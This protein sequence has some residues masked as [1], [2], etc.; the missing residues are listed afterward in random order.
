MKA[1]PL[2]RDA[3][4]G[5]GFLYFIAVSVFNR[6]TSVSLFR[7]ALEYRD[8]DYHDPQYEAQRE[9]LHEQCSECMYNDLVFKKYNARGPIAGNQI[10]NK[11][12]HIVYPR[13][14]S[15]SMIC[16]TRL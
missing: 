2:P 4:Q 5:E 7:Q 16:I 1:L 11:Q 3:R 6:R 9:F 10:Q 14:L 12:H 13:R 15:S 8:R